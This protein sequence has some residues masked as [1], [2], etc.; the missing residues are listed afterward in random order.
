[1]SVYDIGQPSYQLYSEDKPQSGINHFMIRSLHQNPDPINTR[2][3]NSNNVD[4]IQNM[5]RA[6][7]KSKTGFVI[8]RQ[9]DDCLGIIMRACYIEND[10]DS[11]LSPDDFVKGLN[12]MVVRISMPQIASGIKAYL[13]YL[14][15]ASS[16]PTPIARSQNTNIKGQKTLEMRVGL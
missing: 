8:D 7:I 5:L 9:D 14:K 6:Q 4:V 12:D 3:F 10:V 2:F 13:A 11:S 15:D 16:L 1:M